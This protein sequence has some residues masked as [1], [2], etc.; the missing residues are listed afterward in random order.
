[1]AYSRKSQKFYKKLSAGRVVKRPGAL[2]AVA[3]RNHAIKADGKIDLGKMQRVAD[4]SN[5]TRLKRE[6][7][8]ARNF[9][10]MRKPGSSRSTKRSARR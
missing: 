9:S 10:H 2:R 3:K 6:V 5:S 1:M 8:L 7:N 4:R